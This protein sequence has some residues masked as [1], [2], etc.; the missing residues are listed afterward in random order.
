MNRWVLIIS[1][2]HLWLD[3]FLLIFLDSL[4]LQLLW[5]SRTLLW[6][7]H[8]FD[9]LRHFLGLHHTWWLFNRIL[10]IAWLLRRRGRRVALVIFIGV[11]TV[12]IVFINFI[13]VLSSLYIEILIETLKDFLDRLVV[14]KLLEFFRSDFLLLQN[15][16]II[17]LLAFVININEFIIIILLFIAFLLFGYNLLWHECSSPYNHF[18]DVDLRHILLLTPLLA[19]PTTT[20]LLHPLTRS[21]LL[22][23]K[24]CGSRSYMMIF[25]FLS[26]RRNTLTSVGSGC[27]LLQINELLEEAGALES[28]LGEFRF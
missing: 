8:L 14:Q 4:H 28:F 2:W 20:M 7:R 26:S 17:F 23:F 24:N 9:F 13:L 11:L 12:I 5:K 18:L 15:F 21:L 10:F 16:I 19:P 22:F 27:R 6:C 25:L 1:K 3:Y